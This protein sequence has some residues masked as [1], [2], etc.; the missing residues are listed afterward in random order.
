M[1]DP[2]TRGEHA[3]RLLN[4]EVLQ[5]AFTQVR[6]GIIHAFENSPV[7]DIEGQHE[8][9]IMLKLLDNVKGN[10]EQVIANGKLEKTKLEKAKEVVK[11]VVRW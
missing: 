10:I 9:R 4:D 8:L 11:Q 1:I 6:D 5:D 3:E 7:R 2:V